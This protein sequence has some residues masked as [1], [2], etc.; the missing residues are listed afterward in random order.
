MGYFLRG[1]S[2]V[3]V[4]LISASNLAASKL[5]DAYKPASAREVGSA[6]PVSVE[7]SDVGTLHLT[8]YPL[9]QMSL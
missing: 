9:M 2:P 3:P 5:N 4:S 1:A 8:L 6:T 7:V